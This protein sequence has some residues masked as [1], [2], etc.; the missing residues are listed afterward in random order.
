GEG[1]RDWLTRSVLA[2]HSGDVRVRLRGDL[3]DFPFVDPASGEFSVAARIERGVLHYAEAWPRIENIRGELLFERNRMHIA[4]RSGSILGAALANVE[5]D[6]PRLKDPSPR[7]EVSGEARGA[8]AEFLRFVEASP[9]RRMTSGLTSAMSASGFGKLR[10]KLDLPLKDLPNTRVDGEYEVAGNDVV[11]HAQLPPIEGAAGR[12]SFSESALAVR[13]V[14]GRLFGGAVALSGKTQGDGN[15][16]IAAKGEAT[17]AAIRALADH[18]WRRYFAGQAGYEATI[19]IAKGRTHVVLQS[20]LQGVTS[21]LPAPLAK[22]AG[23]TLPLRLET[24]PDD[25]LALR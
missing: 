3:R 5:V 15:L 24:A 4:G 13:D 17:L 18:P 8:T 16:Q 10:L 21:A 22:S 7:L 23:E 12:L 20:A 2:G 19:N 6:I 1:V 14:Q 25:R 9:V 11:V